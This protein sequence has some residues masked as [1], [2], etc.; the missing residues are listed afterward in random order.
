MNA[1]LTKTLVSAAI[2]GLSFMATTAQAGG[3]P[4]PAGTLGAAV[5]S[6]F[7]ADFSAM[8]PLASISTT[9]TAP[10]NSFT[11]TFTSAVYASTATAADA[12]NPGFTLGMGVLD[13][14]YQFTNSPNSLTAVSRL[15]L[16]DFAPNGIPDQL[17]ILAWQ[18]A[19]DP[20]GAGPLFVTGQKAADNAE[21]STN[22]RSVSFNYGTG[23]FA[24]K[25]N[26]GDSS[27]SILLRVNTTNFTT[28]L[29]SAIDGSA[30][31][32]TAY[33]P[34]Q[35]V[36]EPGNYALMLGGLSAVGFLARRRKYS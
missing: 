34:A 9:V 19:A 12:M 14:V 30:A 18:Q 8:T 32:A 7:P 33:V 29:F 27:Y 1:L 28:G 11:G 36:P 15:S 6:P 13:F 16:F 35:A 31:V 2:A 26:P 5:P 22:G 17:S 4:L 21:R 25:L 23:S 3:V 20:D 10:G 24:D